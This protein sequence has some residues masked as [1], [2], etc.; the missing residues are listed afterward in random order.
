[1]SAQFFV[2]DATADLKRSHHHGDKEDGVAQVIGL[3][4]LY[5]IRNGVFLLVDVPAL[6]VGT[7]KSELILQGWLI[8]DDIPV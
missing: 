3:R 8:E 7:K 1:M 2:S 5:C 4:R 6:D